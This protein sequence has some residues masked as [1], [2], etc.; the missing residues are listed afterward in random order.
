VTTN[1]GVNI[2]GVND[3]DPAQMFAD[4][5][6]QARKFGSVAAPYDESAGVDAQGWPAQDAGVVFVANTPNTT[7]QMAWMDGSY[8]LSFNGQAGVQA[9]DDSDVSVGAVSYNSSTNTSTATVTVSPGF[10]RL[11][12]VFTNT[13]RT[14]ASPLHSGITNVSLM[15]P[16]IGGSP[17]PAGTLFTDRFFARLRYFSALRMMDYFATNGSTEAV[18]ID[19]AIPAD[20]SQQQVPP[21]ASQNIDPQYVTGASYEYA[22]QLANQAGKDLWINIPHLAF[23]GSYQFTSTTWATNLALLLKYGSDAGGNPYTGLSGSSGT[24]PQPASGPVNPPLRSGLH[25][26]VEWSNEFFNTANSQNAWIRQQAADAIAAHDADLDWDN[27]TN[28]SDLVWRI[29]AKGDML[30]AN[31]FASVFGASSFGSIYRPIYG[32]Q[33]AYSGSYSGL[34]YL[35]S[36]HG[37]ANQ[38][39][40]A[41]DGAPYDDFS[42]D[43]PNNTLTAEQIVSGMQTYQTQYIVPW[44]T[45]LASIAAQYSLQGGMLAY[46]GGQGAQIQTSGAAAAQVLPAMRGITTTLLDDWSSQGGGLFFYYRLCSADDW[47]LAENIS[48]DIDADTG[49]NANPAESTEQYPKWGAIKQFATTGQ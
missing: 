36:Q 46:E 8:A 26:Y 43:T 29:N 17:H 14:P 34:A 35:Q 47:G 5:M 42:G 24:N 1:L 4:L 11:G 15:R 12:L 41:V 28:V 30:V 9:W 10:E 19:R 20:A 6:K 25:V 21:H 49:Y 45:A 18:W 13:V 33:L 7:G 40:W 23:G 32:G 31:A 2:S 37:G 3:W 39:V 38:Y 48:Y 22:I 27:D 44:T 16:T